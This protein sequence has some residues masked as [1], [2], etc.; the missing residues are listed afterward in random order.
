MEHDKI[1]RIDKAIK[2][3]PDKRSDDGRKYAELEK[4][5]Y[6]G[7]ITISEAD[8]L[9]K[10]DQRRAELRAEAKAAAKGLGLPRKVQLLN[11]DSTRPEEISEIKDNSVDLII[12][13]PPYAEKYLDL[14]DGLAKFASHK[15]KPG[16]SVVF[17]TSEYFL[18]QV[19]NKFSQYTNLTY[20][21]NIKVKMKGPNL[22]IYPKGVIQGGKLMLWYVKGN[23]RLTDTKVVDFIES[24][25]PNK[26]RHEWAQNPIEAEHIIKHLTVSED[27]LVVDPFLGSGAFGIAAIQ[28]GRYFVGIDIDKTVFEDARSHII[29]TSTTASSIEEE[30]DELLEDEEE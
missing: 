8:N 23:K 24:D 21:W 4:G 11:K 7:K 6:N 19:I 1:N 16:G 22:R 28:L 27:S 9:I 20:W 17:M 18:P 14:Y 5:L 30:K 15:L 2:D 29:T 13:D 3:N 10:K 25:R 26:D 12:T